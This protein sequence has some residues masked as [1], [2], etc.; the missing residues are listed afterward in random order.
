MM[1]RYLYNETIPTEIDVNTQQPTSNERQTKTHT[2]MRALCRGLIAIAFASMIVLPMIGCGGGATKSV[3]RGRVIAGTVGQSV[4]A[5]PKDVRFDEQGI[6]DAK[7][8]ILTKKGNA[9]RG[10]GVLTTATSDDF[11][12]FEIVFAGGHYPRDAVQIKVEGDGIY[13]SRSVNFL[14]TNGGEL[15]CVVITRPD[16]VIPEPPEDAKSMREKKK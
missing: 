10:R 3:I 11:G 8:L 2:D 7:V 6:P 16:Y 15:L 13:T 1:L 12:D 4:G 14:P 9:S 5:S